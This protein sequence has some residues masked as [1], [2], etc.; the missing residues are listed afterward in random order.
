MGDA[1]V[2]A[3][4]VGRIAMDTPADL[5]SSKKVRVLPETHVIGGAS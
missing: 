1:P 2:N 4:L 5:A 3:P